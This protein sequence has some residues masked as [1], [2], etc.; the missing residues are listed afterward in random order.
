MAGLRRPAS[1]RDGAGL[2]SWPR[3]HHL[4]LLLHPPSLA[5]PPPP[6]IIPT[7][8]PRIPPRIPASSSA[9]LC[10]RPVAPAMSRPPAPPRPAGGP[11]GAGP[12]AG[13]GPLAPP[14]PGGTAAALKPPPAAPRRVPA[15]PGTTVLPTP[16]FAGYAV[17]WS[18]FFE[19]RLAAAGAANYGLVGNGRLHIVGVPPAPLAAAPAAA[20][21]RVENAFDTQ[22][23]LYAVAWSEAH[24]SQVATAAG[25]GR[26]HL[27][28]INL[29]EH[30]VRAWHEHSREVFG[31]D[32]NN[33][34]KQ[35]FLT[36]SWDAS[37]RV[38]HPERPASVASFT[39]HGG[40]VYAAK[41]SPHTPTLLASAC[42]DGYVRLFDT[43][44]GGAPG[45]PPARPVA[46]LHVGGE[47]LSLDWNKYR[48]MTIA[49][50]ATDRMV[51][52]YDLRNS[53]ASSAPT[54]VLAGHEYAVRTVAWSPHSSDL[55]V[56]GG[57][58]MTARVWNAA[59]APPP[60]A[61]M[62]RFTPQPAS[63]LQAPAGAAATP[64]PVSSGGN[65]LLNVYTGHTEFVIG[66][67]WALFTPNKVATT[68]WDS[69]VQIWNAT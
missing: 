61:P 58:D 16:G 39:A 42:G 7:C 67:S 34:N 13:G 24:E 31:L 50:G 20:G 15:P 11:P 54:G 59:A 48:P 51:K 8:A 46:Q 38:W 3:R 26:V 33:L 30:P 68:A 69:T 22:D 62:W 12:A 44:T 41:W 32:W 53:A 29:R 17:A 40:C 5:A 27:W 18:P 21:A 57:Y 14:P 23:G 64:T 65:P 10:T 4:H 45:A 47:V 25:D 19:G 43:R 55:L 52:T 63:A 36:S 9:P 6:S 2:S 28:D 1:A 60:G 49:T 35:L 37:V 56:S 66:A